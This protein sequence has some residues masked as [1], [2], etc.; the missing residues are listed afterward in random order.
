MH[1]VK[2]ENCIRNVKFNMDY[3]Y[4]CQ[5]HFQFLSGQFFYCSYSRVDR[6]PTWELLENCCSSLT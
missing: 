6:G 5:Y 3:H 1:N 2:Q 4:Y